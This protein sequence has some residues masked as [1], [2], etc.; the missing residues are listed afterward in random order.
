LVEQNQKSLNVSWDEVEKSDKLNSKF[1]QVESN[2]KYKLTFSAEGME[3]KDSPDQKCITGRMVKKAVPVWENGKKTEKTVEKY[4]LQFV[5]N[6]WDGE[7]C[8]KIWN[9]KNA[10]LRNLFR[11][12]AEN[13]LLTS[14]VFVVEIKGELLRGNYSV[15]A[16]DTE[17]K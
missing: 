7:P 15:V 4:V 1:F 2:M 8:L 13:K 12:Y 14:K 5:V 6:S 10:K 11:T 17:K 9:C 3:D 16:L